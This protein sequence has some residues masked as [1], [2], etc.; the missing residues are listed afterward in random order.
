MK[1]A[2]KKV[3]DFH[4]KYGFLVDG[5]LQDKR[6]CAV[7]SMTLKYIGEGLLCKAKEIEI[8]AIKYREIG[9]ER[10][11]RTHL[12]IEEMAELLIGL[13]DMDA[14]ALLDGEDDL[15]YTILGTAVAYTS[16]VHVG[17][18]EVHRSNMTKPRKTKEDPRMR[19]KVG[20]VPPNLKG[21]LAAFKA[22]QR[23]S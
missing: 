21:V 1:D 3:R 2:L 8:D 13:A 22:Q 23:R 19:D 18:D 12:M 9:D 4:K 16:P 11:Y 7:V 15:I 6:H 20:Y 10:L 5:D 14:E 17:F